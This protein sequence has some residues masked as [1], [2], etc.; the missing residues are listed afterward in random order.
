[1]NICLRI[2][3]FSLLVVPACAQDIPKE[4]NKSFAVTVTNP[5]QQA[6]VSWESFPC[7]RSNN[8]LRQTTSS[9]NQKTFWWSQRGSSRPACIR[10]PGSRPVVR[11]SAS[12]TYLSPLACVEKTASLILISCAPTLAKT[13]VRANWPARKHSSA[14]Y[15][16]PTP[17]ER[18]EQPA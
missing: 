9:W 13:H 4:L 8:A 6:R 16:F 12:L 5:S 14:K 17:M 1:M 15:K 18:A 11:Q 10:T 3:F 2:V 7:T